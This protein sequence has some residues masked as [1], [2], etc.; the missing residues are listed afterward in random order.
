MCIGPIFEAFTLSL[1]GLA[2]YTL[3]QIEKKKEESPK[4]VAVKG[5]GCLRQ[6]P[7]KSVF[8]TAMKVVFFKIIFI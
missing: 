2:Y 5:G 1:I 4:G 3:V 8:G 7:K 6:E